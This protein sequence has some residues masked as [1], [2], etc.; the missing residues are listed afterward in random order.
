M[1][2][3]SPSLVPKGSASTVI[4]RYGFW[5]VADADWT[6]LPAGAAWKLLNSLTTP[7]LTVSCTPS[8]TKNAVGVA[9]AA[10]AEPGGAPRRATASMAPTA[11]RNASAEQRT[12]FQPP[13][14]CPIVLEASR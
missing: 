12:L 9:A 5:L 11:V 8:R 2:G 10:V 7:A 13:M 6:A 3:S 1:A 4:S 14:T